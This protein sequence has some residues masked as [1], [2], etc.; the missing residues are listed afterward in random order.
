MAFNVQRIAFQRFRVA[1]YRQN[2]FIQAHNDNKTSE[3][4]TQ[5][6]KIVRIYLKVKNKLFS[7]WTNLG[8]F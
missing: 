2:H 5:I 3:N 1:A 7:R 8:K 4:W 6:Q